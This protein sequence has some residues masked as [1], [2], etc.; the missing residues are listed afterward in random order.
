MAII[1]R[2]AFNARLTIDQVAYEGITHITADDLAYAKELGLSLKLIGTAERRDGGISVRVHPAFLYA[3]HPL[4]SVNGSFNAV[5]IES[6]AITEVTLSGPGAGG[7]Q[8]ASAVLG[9]VIS[10]IIPPPTLPAPPEEHPL[11]TD[12]ESAFYLSLEVADHPGVLAQ[13]AEILGLQGVSVKSVLQK[14]LGEDARLAMV[15]HPV[16]ES[17]FHAAVS[18]IGRLDFLRSEPRVIRVIEE[19]FES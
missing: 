16:L 1:A 11:V 6:P 13:V 18:L 9:D 12:V 15:M 8:T 2:L 10:A 5:T 3:D 19:T 17:K 4:S 14:G 7:T